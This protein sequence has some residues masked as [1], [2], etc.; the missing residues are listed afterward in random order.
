MKS[1]MIQYGEK[2]LRGYGEYSIEGT[3]PMLCSSVF[4][5]D[6]ILPRMPR[7]CRNSILVIQIGPRFTPTER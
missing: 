1:G 3:E 2:Y 4:V 6:I 5:V 7:Q